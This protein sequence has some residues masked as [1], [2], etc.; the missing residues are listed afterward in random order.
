MTA[1]MLHVSFRII[2]VILRDQTRIGTAL[3]VVVEVKLDKLPLRIAVLRVRRE[4][5]AAFQLLNA[6][7]FIFINTRHLDVLA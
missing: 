3:V 6:A 1:R 2:I 5:I 4:N 7:N